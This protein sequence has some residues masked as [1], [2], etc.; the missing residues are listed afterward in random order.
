MK[1]RRLP[2]FTSGIGYPN[3]YKKHSGNETKESADLSSATIDFGS[4]NLSSFKCLA[5]IAD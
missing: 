5:A 4:E 1:H 2:L 3:D